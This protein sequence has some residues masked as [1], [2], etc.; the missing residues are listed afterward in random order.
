MRERTQR[1]LFWAIVP[2]ILALFCVQLAWG[3]VTIEPPSGTVVSGWPVNFKITGLAAEDLPR[4]AIRGE[5]ASCFVE[6]KHGKTG[7]LFIEFEAA[8]NGPHALVLAIS[9]S[10]KPIIIVAAIDV[11]GDDPRPDPEPDPDPDPDPD[12]TPPPGPRTIVVIIERSTPIPT[13]DQAKVLRDLDQ[14]KEREGYTPETYR[15]ADPDLKDSEGEPAKWLQPYL[16]ALQRHGVQHPAI[17]VDAEPF[18]SVEAYDVVEPLPA[19]GAE[20]IQVIEKGGG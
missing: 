18:G 14:W 4:V 5:P 17:I 12:P 11:G 20:A 9:T 13:P 2:F 8:K 3:E 7:G 19:T 16:Q 6:L 15:I 1:W 10:Q